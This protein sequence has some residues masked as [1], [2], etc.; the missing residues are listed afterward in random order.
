MFFEVILF[1]VVI[2][3]A[4]FLTFAW[5]K[6]SAKNGIWRV[7]EGTLLLMALVGGSLGAITAQ[8]MFRH[9]TRKEPFRS[10]LY[11]IAGAQ[12]VLIIAM[13]YP[14]SREFIIAQFFE[15]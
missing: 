11:V 4:A 7:S 9:K 8:Q 12:V 10:T 6:Y 2:N 1:I 15:G 13:S 5:D 14:P 3:T